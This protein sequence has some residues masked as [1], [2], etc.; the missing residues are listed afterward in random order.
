MSLKAAKDYIE[1]AIRSTEKYANLEKEKNKSLMR[2]AM[3]TEI[4]T[5]NISYSTFQTNNSNSINKLS[6]EDLKELYGI[7]IVNV[8]S[9]VGQG[10]IFS[11][12]KQAAPFLKNK[13][14]FAA[15]SGCILITSGIST[16][17]VGINYKSLRQLVTAVVNKDY[18]FQTS[19]LGAD[20]KINS[21][22]GEI[23]RKSLLELGHTATNTPFAETIKKVISNSKDIPLLNSELNTILDDLYSTQ[24]SV[25]YEFI[26][27]AD[28]SH[29]PE[30]TIS[31]VIQPRDVNSKLSVEEGKLYR[32][33][34][35]SIVK[36]SNLLKIPGSNTLEQ[37]AIQYYKDKFLTS[38]T[39]KK[40][41]NVKK[42]S[43]VK[44]SV[45]VGGESKK[46]K[47]ATFKSTD[48][49][50]SIKTAPQ[51]DLF[52]LQNLINQQLQD[53]VSA[54][55]GDGTQ[56]GILNY[57]T[58]R[59]A[60]SVKLERLT[61]SKQGMISAFYSYMKYPY[62]TFSAGG[63]QSNPKSRDPKLLIAKSIREIAQQ[64]VS[65]KL[66]AILV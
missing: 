30:G 3:D 12:T 6:T 54:N 43:P 27:K 45:K 20:V 29:L 5:L 65:N 53:V 28:N 60:N 18:Y 4:H 59:F 10:R 46:N 33:F 44:G 15:G 41:A 52:G 14:L 16:S 64:A 47:V 61:I 7:F 26:N 50:S 24:V 39:G 21:K 34:L 66:R 38:I 13:D 55:M 36:N 25:G 58:G 17:I 23:F 31:L 63:R 2:T 8:K 9:L 19:P 62:A 32:K 56:D 40:R 48:F 22:T 51:V 1:K 35:T 42:H 37:D 57:R 49:T 11:S